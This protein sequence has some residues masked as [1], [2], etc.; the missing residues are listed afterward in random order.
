[1][2][3]DAYVQEKILLLSKELLQE[4]GIIVESF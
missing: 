2:E 1:M 3:V 4:A